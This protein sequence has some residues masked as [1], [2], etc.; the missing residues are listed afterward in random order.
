MSHASAVR[1]SLCTPPLVSQEQ[2]LLGEK[3]A[4]ENCSRST[5]ILTQALTEVTRLTATAE[6]RR[7]EVEELLKRLS[8]QDLDARAASEADKEHMRVLKEQHR[9]EK[10]LLEAGKEQLRAEK[11]SLCSAAKDT[12][13]QIMVLNMRNSRLSSELMEARAAHTEAAK[14]WAVEKERQEV[15]ALAEREKQLALARED[16]NASVSQLCACC[17]GSGTRTRNLSLQSSRRLLRRDPLPSA[18]P[19]PFFSLS[20]AFLQ[21]ILC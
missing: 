21:P 20:S 11:G 7:L 8:R 3:L 15:E 13:E 4:T 10:V 2:R 16:R 6:Q 12:S 5:A 18:F 17:I 19:H 14:S 1:F 9:A